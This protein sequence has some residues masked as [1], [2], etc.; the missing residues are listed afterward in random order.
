M[1]KCNFCRKTFSNERNLKV[2]QTTAK[3]CLIV[4]GKISKSDFLCEYCKKEYSSEFSKCRHQ[5]RCPEKKYSE[6]AKAIEDLKDELRKSRNT[7]V[8]LRDQ[9][10]VI[11]SD[12]KAM[13][14]KK[15]EKI[16]RLEGKYE[17]CEDHYTKESSKTK[18]TTTYHITQQKLDSIPTTTIEPLTI[19]Y[20]RKKIEEEYTYDKFIE[21]PIGS[22]VDLIID[23]TS[24]INEDGVRE[25]NYACTDV[26]RH[27]CHRFIETRDWLK[28]S[29][30]DFINKIL[31]ELAEPV[32]EYFA[33]VKAVTKLGDVN[34]MREVDVWLK[35]IGDIQAFCHGVINPENK[36]RTKVFGKVRGRIC[37]KTAV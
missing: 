27:N 31:N 21:D 2:H 37:N 3:Y 35:K 11:I 22:V 26:S 23:M 6:N 33:R 10:D 28:D 16:A 1:S 12:L 13:I 14:S 34:T 32:E 20:V 9:T 7:G 36:S 25:M 4:Q 24:V 8:M 17:V 30:A 15:N 19:D 18:N 5:N 29:G